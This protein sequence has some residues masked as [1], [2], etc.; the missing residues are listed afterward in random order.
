MRVLDERLQDHAGHDARPASPASISL[1]TRSCGPKRITSM[2]RYSSIDVELFAQRD[3]V[4]LAAQQAAQQ[5]DS[6]CTTIRAV[7]GCE[8]MS[9]EIDVSVLKR[10]CGLIWLAS[11]EI[12]ARQQQLLLLLQPVLDARVVPDLDR[13]WRR[14]APWRAAPA[15]RQ[16][17]DGALR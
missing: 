16:P 15:R 6:R 14:T 4:I 10:K 11:A 1:R 3:E 13:A 5:A 17:A 12:F 9:D 2:S 7:S 8:R